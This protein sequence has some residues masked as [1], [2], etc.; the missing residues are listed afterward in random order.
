MTTHS[1]TNKICPVCG[2]SDKVYRSRAKNKFEKFIN[3]IKILS[4]Y[5]CHNCNWRGIRFRKI[6][7]EIKLT[8]ILRFI[9][10]IFITYLLILYV[11]NEFFKI[12]YFK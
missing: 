1:K 3:R 5:R 12:S 10:L 6:R 2:S 8:K 7:L 4:M 9:I 11:L